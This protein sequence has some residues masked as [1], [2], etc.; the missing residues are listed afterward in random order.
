MQNINTDLFF[1]LASKDLEDKVKNYNNVKQLLNRR[2]SFLN[3][4]TYVE[5]S[6]ESG[7]R[8]VLTSEGSVNYAVYNS[9]AKLNEGDNLPASMPGI[10]GASVGFVDKKPF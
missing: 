2:S 1:I 5:R 8:K 9:N 6:A 3:V 4:S 7:L 10:N